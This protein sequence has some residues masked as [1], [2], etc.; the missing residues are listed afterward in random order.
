[1]TQPAHRRIDLTVRRVCPDPEEATPRAALLSQRPVPSF[2]EYPLPGAP[3]S[4]SS[5]NWDVGRSR[6]EMVHCGPFTPAREG[7]SVHIS[8]ESSCIRALAESA[9]IFGSPWRSV[10]CGHL[11]FCGWLV[12]LRRFTEPTLRP[13][14]IW[15]LRLP[16]Q[17]GVDAGSRGPS[18]AA[19]EEHHVSHGG[20]LIPTLV[21]PPTSFESCEK[22]QRDGFPAASTNCYEISVA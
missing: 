2:S 4:A 14:L 1:M 15:T 20:A 18:E 11:N 3:G 19:R 13:D 22:P 12:H 10:R 9:C 7:S 21:G 8:N 6:D 5:G 17:L 16:L